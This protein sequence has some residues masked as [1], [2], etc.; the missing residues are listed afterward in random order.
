MLKRRSGMSLYRSLACGLFAMA[1]AACS[2]GDKDKIDSG[3]EPDNNVVQLPDN[4]IT[5]FSFSDID[6]KRFS[7]G[8][9]LQFEPVIGTDSST[10][11]IDS[12]SLY[13]ADDQG[14]KLGESWHVSSNF[15][16]GKIEI[17]S[18]TSLPEGV[19][20]I[21]LYTN[22]AA[23][24]SKGSVFIEF[25]DFVSIS[26]AP[27]NIIT[28]A[29]FVDQDGEAGTISGSIVI[30]ISD[31]FEKDPSRAESLVLFWNNTQGLPISA[32]S[33]IDGSNTIELKIPNAMKLPLDTDSFVI[34]TANRIGLS[35]SSY[36]LPV[37]DLVDVS[38]KP[39]YG[40]NGWYFRDKDGDS[41][42][43]S[44]PLASNASIESLKSNQQT[45]NDKVESIWLYWAD[46]N[47]N[48]SGEAWLKTNSDNPYDID[49]PENTVIPDGISAMLAFANNRVGEA[50]SG[51]LIKFHDFKGNTLMS[52]KGGNELDNWTY[53]EERPQIAIHRTA[54]QGGLCTFDNGLVA[55]V[56]MN[57]T[58]DETL[59]NSGQAAENVADDV[60]Y[61][62]YQ[63]TCNDNPEHNERPLVDDVGV[64]TYSTLNDAMFYGTLVY[65]TFL[66][67][68]AEPALDEKLRLRVHYGSQFHNYAFWDGAYANFSDNYPFQFSMLSLDS[69][70]HEIG[71][72]VLN[73]ISNLNAFEHDISVDALTVHEAFSDIS[74]VMAKHDFNGPGDI[75]HHGEENWG[76]TRRLNQIK[77]ESGAVLSM[78][79]YEDAGDNFYLR[80][81]LMTYPFYLMS[82]SWGLEKTYQLYLDAA[83][84]CW[85]ADMDM[86]FA[87]DCIKQ[88]AAG[89]DLELQIVVDAFKAVKIKT[90]EEGVLSHFKVE[91]FKLIN[92][93]RDSSISTSNVKEWL[94]D[95]GD[96]QTSTQANPIHTYQQSGTYQVKLTVTDESE[97]Q[98]SF[99]REI[100]VT[101]QYCSA[102][103]VDE[104]DVISE[105]TIA[106]KNIDFV[107]TKYDYTD[108]TINLDNP[109]N[110]PITV[111]SLVVNSERSTTWRVWIDLNDNGLFGDTPQELVLDEFSAE[112][113]PYSAELII[114]LSNLEKSDGP[115]YMR[116]AGDYAL[117]TP[118]SVQAGRMLDVKVD[119]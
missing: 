18:G 12:L 6:G 102:I 97:S 41:G 22:N 53:G 73:R 98:D 56:D 33:T 69:V 36:L 45:A 119:W 77:T 20:G 54:E 61:P 113:E 25:T 85:Q 17:A 74:G 75:W 95:F 70:A 84:Y 112:G 24:Q 103:G 60:A 57:N 8:G 93:F 1:V 67:Y 99:I 79:D 58:R 2:G 7:I 106:G 100:S 49:V 44:G 38:E 92:E 40:M 31:I 63:F 43:I 28:K 11:P 82:E 89:H 50:E 107:S 35:D 87:A 64:W 39:T 76:R 21:L 96:G 116:V 114:D 59:H 3:P 117:I 48:K 71:H 23:G 4:P 80:I 51:S 91:N 9:T 37:N 55:V 78:L 47:G 16:D 32:V 5:N 101:D 105:V 26:E 118:C 34:Y 109:T 110:V 27:K 62:A 104:G 13:W 15:S 111:S 65:D 86:T 94:W 29:G 66:K 46:Q 90:F 30:E 88:Q 14:L 52:G 68:L 42:E 10:K 83:R 115:K 19:A 108:T 81:G 72:G